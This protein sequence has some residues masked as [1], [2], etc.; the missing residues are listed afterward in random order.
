M[1]LFIGFRFQFLLETQLLGEMHGFVHRF[2]L[3]FL[4]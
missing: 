4:I 3:F 1:G 2:P